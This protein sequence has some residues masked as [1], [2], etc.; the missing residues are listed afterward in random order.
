MAPG[1]GRDRPHRRVLL[2]AIVIVFI[3]RVFRSALEMV[4]WCMRSGLAR[5]G[6]RRAAASEYGVSAIPRAG[7]GYSMRE[8]QRPE[9]RAWRSQ[10]ECGSAL[11]RESLLIEDVAETLAKVAVKFDGAVDDR[12][13]GSAGALEV[14]RQLL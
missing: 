14:L 3:K 11:D 9:R 6:A 1:D 7:L 8:S 10:G 13:A 4:L 12:A 2:E 5:G